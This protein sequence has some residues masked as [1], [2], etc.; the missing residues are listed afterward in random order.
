MN[1]FRINSNPTS[2]LAYKNLSTPQFTLRTTLARLSS[3]LRVDTAV[4]GGVATDA[5]LTNQI[6]GMKQANTSAQQTNNLIQAA[7]DG[8]SDISDALHRMR[9]LAVNSV[10]EVMN[11][12]ARTNANLEF[13]TL[14]DEVSQIAN[15]ARY[16]GIHLLNGTDYEN[17]INAENSTADDVQGISIKELPTGA[18][19]GVYTL[20]DSKIQASNR[21]NISNLSGTAITEIRYN[22]SSVQPETYTIN[23]QLNSGTTTVSGVA[24]TEIDYASSAQIGDYTLR[25]KVEAGMADIS[26]LL[27]TDIN[28]ISHSA[29]VQPGTYTVSASEMPPPDNYVLSLDGTTDYVALDA[30][31]DDIGGTSSAGI[32]V[33]AWI[34]P[35]TGSSSQKNIIISTDRSEYWRLSYGFGA[36]RDRVSWSTT[37]SSDSIHDMVGSTQ[38]DE[39]Q[40]Y[41]VAAVYDPG[42]GKKYIYVNGE[43]DGE[44]NAYSAG[45]VLGTGV[46]RYGFIGV[47]S[48]ASSFNANRGPAHWFNG[49]IDEVRV[50]DLARSQ[51]EIQQTRNTYLTGDESDLASYWNFNDGTANDLTGNG[52]HGTLWGDAQIPA[53]V[54]NEITLSAAQGSSGIMAV[55]IPDGTSETVSYTQTAGSQTVN[56]SNLNLTIDI[57]DGTTLLGQL[58]S[59]KTFTINP[60]LEVTTPTGITREA[61]YQFNS[62]SQTLT[63]SDLSLEVNTDDTQAMTAALLNNAKTFTVPSTLVINSPNTTASETA[64]GLSDS[65]IDFS[66]LGLEVHTTNAQTTNITLLN[67][68]R[69]FLVPETRRLIMTDES[70]IQQSLEYRAS[71]NTRLDFSEFGIQSDISDSYDSYSNGLDATRIEVSPVRSQLVRAEDSITRQLRMDVNNVTANGLEI[72]NESIA[73]VD[74]AR[75]AIISLDSTINT[76]NSKKGYLGAVRESLTFAMSDLVN[77]TWNLGTSQ[78]NIGTADLA[79][80]VA[81]L[82]KNQI[83]AQSATAMVTQANALSQNILGLINDGSMQLGSAFGMLSPTTQIQ[84]LGASGSMI[85]DVNFATETINMAKAQILS[86]SH[87]AMFI[88]ANISYIKALQLLK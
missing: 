26:N 1:T 87:N 66:S 30:N 64:Y 10:S 36:S 9:E 19:K 17:Q 76:V 60:T 73:T 51:E 5:Q 3:G 82:A 74:Y 41:H 23:S 40:W 50:W 20:A 45:S 37:S 81:E 56:F 79:I 47:G 31:Q 53:T 25:A 8:L 22:P 59:P 70:G 48:E 21:A 14:K 77:Q 13:Q 12:V 34:K 65:V 24:A 78:A 80:E 38:L 68:S 32:T 67:S 54:N 16:K 52:N 27:D 61:G 57:S 88:Q 63:F 49:L 39:G 42:A 28:Q 44:A 15:E 58:T 69:S 11:D 86:D 84:N 85:Q 43:L 4:D 62:S 35:G 33:E 71:Y 7:E 2:A 72:E 83:L 6:Q 55:E 29:L 46:S 75:A 18:R